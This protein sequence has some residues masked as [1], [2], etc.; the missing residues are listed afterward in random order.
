MPVVLLLLLACR[1]DGDESPAETDP[2]DT[3]AS[4]GGAWRVGPEDPSVGV[5]GIAVDSARGVVYTTNLH[6]P[7]LSR[8]DAETG[9]RLDGVDL[10]P[11]IGDLYAGFP[12]VAYDPVRDRVWLNAGDLGLLVALDGATYTPVAR[13]EVGGETKHFTVDEAGDVWVA[14]VAGRRVV[15]VSDDAVAATY[16]VGDG[17]EAIAAD[18]DWVVAT[19]GEPMRFVPVRRADGAV[20]APIA[21]GAWGGFPGIDAVRDV[22]WVPD[23]VAETVL[24]VDLTAD[25][26]TLSE[27]IAQGA[28]PVSATYVAA[29]DVVV[30]VDRQ[31]AGIPDGGTYRG[32]PSRLVAHDAETGAVVWTGLVGKTAHFVA[33]DDV[34][35]RLWTANED[36]LDLSAVDASGAEVIRTDKMGRTLDGVAYFERLALFPSHLTDTLEVLDRDSGAVT[37]IPTSGWPLAVA[38]DP[39]ARRAYVTCQDEALVDVV[40][41]DALTVIDTLDTGAGSHQQACD[42]LCDGHSAFTDILWDDGAL[43]VTSPPRAELIRLDPDTGAVETWPLADAPTATGNRLHTMAVVRVGDRLLVYEP[44]EATVYAVADGAVVASAQAPVGDGKPLVVDG[45]GRV[46]AGAVAFDSALN[47]VASLDGVEAVAAHGDWLVATDNDH[48]VVLDAATLERVAELAYA[49][50]TFPPYR[51]EDDARTPFQYGVDDDGRLWLLNVF[52]ATAET[53]TLPFLGEI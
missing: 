2:P 53:R 38:I 40:D 50:L 8:V 30:V 49:D 25:P 17:V 10:R 47:T 21:Y 11:V 23:R 13:V 9:A 26:P 14:D 39:D 52:A 42:P 46:W 1:R 19:H 33:W 48:I 37:S 18:A 12:Y 3:G 32:E 29:L 31:G 36:S 35:A 7:F 6:V 51:L 28:D 24:R 15:H 16:D 34:R 5:Y 45:L 43:W 27:P 20:G 22:A 41:L 44:V 4:G